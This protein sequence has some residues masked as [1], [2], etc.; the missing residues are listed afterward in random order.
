MREKGREEELKG[1]N[2]WERKMERL[3]RSKIDS[4]TIGKFSEQPHDFKSEIAPLENFWSS[5]TIT[6]VKE[7]HWKISGAATRFREWESTI[8]GPTDEKNS[9]TIGRKRTTAPLRLFLQKNTHHW[10]SSDRKTRIGRCNQIFWGHY[11]TSRRDHYAP[12]F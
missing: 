10:G 7:H 2:A 8:E 1:K 11:L 6:R 4:H 5:H 3:L 9:H 12:E